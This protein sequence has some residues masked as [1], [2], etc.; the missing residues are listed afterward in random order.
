M[1]CMAA[2]S[3]MS[4]I[5]N[6][7]K[8]AAVQTGKDKAQQKMDSTT[9]GVSG[10]GMNMGSAASSASTQQT[11]TAQSVKDAAKDKAKEKASDAAGSAIDKALNK[12]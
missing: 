11:P 12:Y 7:A 6:A 5:G 4:D 10:G 9:M 8:D 1:M 2:D 3:M